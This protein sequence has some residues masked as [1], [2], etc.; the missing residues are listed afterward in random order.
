MPR[1]LRASDTLDLLED[2]VVYT[3][4]ALQSDPYAVALVHHTD[5]WMEMVAEARL[6]DRKT[7]QRT[8]NAEARRVVSNENLDD[9]CEAFGRDLLKD[10]EGDTRHTRW[11]M[12]FDV[13]VGRF[14]RQALRRQVQ[15]V[16]SWLEHQ[17]P[18]LEP[19]REALTQWTAAATAAVEDTQALAVERARNQISREQLAEDLSRERDALHQALLDVAQAHKL[20]GTWPEVFFRRLDLSA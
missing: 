6:L 9:T 7:R 17:D 1:A 4:S 18:A 8:V 13:S 10:V 2:E 19:H 14:V 15:A 5:G 20:P 3:I 12:F 11:R 16:A